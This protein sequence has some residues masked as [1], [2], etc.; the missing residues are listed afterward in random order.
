MLVGGLVHVQS[1][2]WRHSFIDCIA[3]Q[4]SGTY[5]LSIKCP[6]VVD[7]GL[8]LREYRHCRYFFF[9]RILSHFYVWSMSLMRRL[10]WTRCW[11]SSPDNSLSP[12]SR[13]WCYPTTSPLVFLSFFSPAPPSP[14]LSCLR[15]IILFSIL[16]QPTCLYFLGNFSPLSCPSNYFIPNTVHS[17]I[18][19][20]S[21]SP[22]PTYSLVLSSLSMSRHRRPLHRC[23]SYNRLMYFHRHC[24]YTFVRVS[25]ETSWPRTLK[26]L[27]I[28][29][30]SA[31]ILWN[32]LPH[33]LKCVANINIFFKSSEEAYFYMLV[34]CIIVMCDD[35]YFIGTIICIACLQLY[36]CLFYVILVF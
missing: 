34:S 18:L 3:G 16:L 12:T 6:H 24:G 5:N 4:R 10:H 9:F 20:A 36:A 29:S 33:K 25:M 19:T 21:Y 26:F 22:H 27:H 14:S 17:S 8:I 28:F 31:P 32:A 35:Q 2:Y 13:S 30:V 1:D 23:W 11:S 7:F 15:I